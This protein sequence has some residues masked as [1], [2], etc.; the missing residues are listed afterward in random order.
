MKSATFFIIFLINLFT[1]LSLVFAWEGYDYQNKTSIDISEG[2]LVREGYVIQFYETKSDNFRTA[3]IVY[4]Q[5]VAMGTEI[6]LIDLDNNQT[7]FFIMPN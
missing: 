6:E 4:I 7:R 1:N 3:K 2:N 5:S